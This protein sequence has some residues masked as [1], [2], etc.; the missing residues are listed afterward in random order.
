MMGAGAMFGI[1]SIIAL[2]VWWLCRIFKKNKINPD[3]NIIN[4]DDPQNFTTQS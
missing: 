1:M 3:N 2:V 4:A